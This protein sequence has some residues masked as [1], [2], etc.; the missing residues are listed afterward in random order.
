MAQY[1]FDIPQVPASSG[2]G[3]AALVGGLG[4]AGA[5]ALRRREKP[6]ELESS[7]YREGRK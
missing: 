6:I 4:A 1:S 5:Y 7:E 2:L 3:L